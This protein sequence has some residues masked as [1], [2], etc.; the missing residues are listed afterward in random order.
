MQT[1]WLFRPELGTIHLREFD[2][3]LGQSLGGF[4]FTIFN[5]VGGYIYSEPYDFIFLSQSNQK[6]SFAA[7]D[8]DH[9]GPFRE[10]QKSDEVY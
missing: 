1:R 8:I 3:R 10:V 7:S 5:A 2:V 4:L 6:L 9:S